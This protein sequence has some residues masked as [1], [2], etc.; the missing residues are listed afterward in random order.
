MAPLAG[1][2]RSGRSQ[3]EI[4]T[5]AVRQSP[6]RPPASL[7]SSGSPRTLF[8]ARP[9]P[10]PP[11]HTHSLSITAWLGTI[12]ANSM[13]PF[14]AVLTR[15]PGLQGHPLFFTSSEWFPH[16][17]AFNSP[18]LR[19]QENPL[20]IS[21][22]FSSLIFSEFQSLWPPRIFNSVSSAHGNFESLFRLPLLVLQP[23]GSKLGQS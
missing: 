20:Q 6:C 13:R 21:G 1:A 16:T 14:M 10:S 17:H 8:L 7:R 12:R 15:S 19:T 3:E 11:L 18:L 2:K 22:A 9:L 4:A 23:P 5:L